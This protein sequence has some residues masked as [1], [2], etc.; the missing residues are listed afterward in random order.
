MLKTLK[1]QLIL[2]RLKGTMKP[3][4]DY[5]KRRAAQLHGER[6]ERFMQAVG[7]VDAS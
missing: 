6:K 3:D 5:A 2:H 7:L 4:P 1:R